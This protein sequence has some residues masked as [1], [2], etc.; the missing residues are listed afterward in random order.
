MFHRE[1]S[2]NAADW[3]EWTE[4][5]PELASELWPIVLHE[6]RSSADVDRGCE[7]MM[8]GELTGNLEELRKL[9]RQ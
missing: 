8:M 7:A 4:Q 2:W 6:I 1:F 5:N 9:Q 3:I